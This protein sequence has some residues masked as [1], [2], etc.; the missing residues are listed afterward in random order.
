MQAQKGGLGGSD[1]DYA[2]GNGAGAVQMGNA[3]SGTLTCDKTD[4]DQASRLGINGARWSGSDLDLLP[5]IATGGVV[6][7]E[8]E[9]LLQRVIGLGL[10]ADG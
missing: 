1:A 8:R 5:Q 4:P 10:L 6:G 9:G 7:I 3:S 2:G